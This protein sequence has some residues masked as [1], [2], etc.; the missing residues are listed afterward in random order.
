M[1]RRAQRVLENSPFFE[2]F[3][4]SDIAQLATLAKFLRYDAGQEIFAEEELAEQFY[5]LVS[6]AVELLPKLVQWLPSAALDEP[7]GTIGAAAIASSGSRP[8]NERACDH[9]SG[10]GGEMDRVGHNGNVGQFSQRRDG[11]EHLVHRQGSICGEH[12]AHHGGNGDRGGAVDPV[13]GFQRDALNRMIAARVVCAPSVLKTP[14]AA[15]STS[16]RHC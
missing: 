8:G 11:A 15:P 12:A 6:G 1:S 13:A 14:P 10:I 2:G 9:T 7:I 16:I 5:V 3:A 4:Q